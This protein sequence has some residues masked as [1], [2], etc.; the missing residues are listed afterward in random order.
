MVGIKLAATFFALCW[1]PGILAKL[2]ARPEPP[3]AHRDGASIEAVE[4]AKA[5]GPPKRVE[6]PRKEMMPI[7]HRSQRE[8]LVRQKSLSPE[9]A[10]SQASLSKE[11]IV[12]DKKTIWDAFFGEDDSESEYKPPLYSTFDRLLQLNSEICC[13]LK[14]LE[15]AFARGVSARTIDDIW[16]GYCTKCGELVFRY[17]DEWQ[18]C[19]CGDSYG[20]VWCPHCDK[21]VWRSPS[22]IENCFCPSRKSTTPKAGS[23]GADTANT[24]KNDGPPTYLQISA[25][26]QQRIQDLISKHDD[27]G[28]KAFLFKLGIGG[29]NDNDS[30]DD[31][32]IT[33]LKDTRKEYQEGDRPWSAAVKVLMEVGECSGLIVGKWLVLTAKHCSPQKGAVVYPDVF[34]NLDEDKK[35]TVVS[36]VDAVARKDDE[37]ANDHDCYGV[38]D[39]WSLMVVDKPIGQD[40]HIK[41]WDMSTP[42]PE[43]EPLYSNAGYSGKWHDGWLPTKQDGIAI[44]PGK[45]GCDLY[46]PLRANSFTAP[47]LSGS[48]LLYK[49]NAN[50]WF[51]TG[52]LYGSLY[53]D[54]EHTK[55]LCSLYSTGP[56]LYGAWQLLTLLTKDL[57]TIR[58]YQS[59]KPGRF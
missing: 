44:W 3:M 20:H 33:P 37:G 52:A 40:F 31:K 25:D 16:A 57:R 50:E 5:R 59:M 35:A 28:L 26:D 14:P 11:R 36:V 34:N 45:R 17:P 12:T 56:G 38:M 42:L 55:R 32:G 54:D 10:R 39:D 6:A 2:V 43:G 13:P 8:E 21:T 27:A 23:G 18:T 41:I 51:S 4:M 47:G 15:K 22:I 58:N 7:I 1:A 24:G 19:Y 29:D 30:S 49:D 9:Q 53:D 48:S 46:G